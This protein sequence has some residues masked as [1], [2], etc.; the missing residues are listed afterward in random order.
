MDRAGSAF[1]GSG[2]WRWGKG[3][4]RKPASLGGVAPAEATAVV[5]L[6]GVGRGVVVPAA[7]VGGGGVVPAA[8]VRS[9]GIVSAAGVGGGGIVP[10]VGVRVGMGM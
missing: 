3:G 2:K 7:G 8:G 4:S 5:L 6:V 1:S 10:A 9:S